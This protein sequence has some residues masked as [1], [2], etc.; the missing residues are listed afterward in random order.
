LSECLTI[1]PTTVRAAY[2]Y[3]RA[4]QLPAWPILLAVIVALWGGTDLGAR[5]ANRLE[6]TT[7]RRALVVMV[8]AMT[9]YMVWRALSPISSPV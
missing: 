6:R 7:L 2:V 5:L 8:T 3:W 1:M 9:L 4:G